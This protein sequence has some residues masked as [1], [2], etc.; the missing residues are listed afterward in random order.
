MPV[1]SWARGPRKN[2]ALI[3]CGGMERE[4]RERFE[5]IESLLHAMAERE[6]QLEIRFNHRM[7][8]AEQRMDR[9]EQ[10]MDRAEQR[11]EKSDRRL[12]ATRKLVEA[13]I[14]LVIHMGQR[15]KATEAELKQLA[16]S[17]KAFIDALRRGGNGSGRAS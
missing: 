13:G 10:R 17:Q 9:A 3:Y 1:Y 7:D 5:R 8:R 6:N 12:E 15:Q 16:K 11:M 2:A 14:K 4:V